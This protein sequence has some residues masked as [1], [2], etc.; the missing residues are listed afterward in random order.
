M[1]ALNSYKGTLFYDAGLYRE[2]TITTFLV[3]LRSIL[4]AIVRDPKVSI[5]N[6]QLLTKEEEHQQLFEWTGLAQENHK[7]CIH[8]LYEDQARSRPDAIAVI[9][10][11]EHLT[12]LELYRGA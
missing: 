8:E 5:G 4:A 9:Y 3:R 11:G 7:A 12:Y 10:E 1:K 2:E 6:L